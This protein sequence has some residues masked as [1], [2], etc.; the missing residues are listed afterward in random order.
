MAKVVSLDVPLV[1]DNAR[2]VRIGFHIGLTNRL[3]VNFARVKGA[4]SVNRLYELAFKYLLMQQL[5]D[6]PKHP[7][8]IALFVNAAVA[9]PKHRLTQF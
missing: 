9:Q 8:S 6:D 2:D 5:K 7:L 1:L 4:G 3:D